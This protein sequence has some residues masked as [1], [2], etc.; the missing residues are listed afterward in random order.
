LVRRHTHLYKLL[1]QD[2]SLRIADRPHIRCANTA[3]FQDF[4][5]REPASP[6]LAFDR[7][8]SKVNLFGLRQQIGEEL[9]IRLAEL[10][11]IIPTSR[12][13]GADMKHNDP[14]I[15]RVPRHVLLD[16]AHDAADELHEGTEVGKNA[17]DHGDGEVGMIEAL[18]EHASLT[19]TSSS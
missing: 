3:F 17:A 18:A 15:K 9:L 14:L 11:E 10:P 13:I 2:G 6:R 19:I 16:R 5:W 4:H 1:E 12:D 8:P 7:V